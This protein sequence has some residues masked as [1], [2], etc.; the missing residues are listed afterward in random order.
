M[1]G[2]FQAGGHCSGKGEV[3]GDMGRKWM[4]SAAI[5]IAWC[6]VWHLEGTQ[7]M[8]Q[9][10]NEASASQWMDGQRRESRMADHRVTRA[11]WDPLPEGPAGSKHSPGPCRAGAAVSPRHPE[12]QPPEG[13]LSVF[14]LLFTLPRT[15]T[16]LL[17]LLQAAFCILS[18]AS[19]PSLIS[20]ISAIH[21]TR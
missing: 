16:A 18:C 12:G 1:A 9:G 11:L 6:G 5:L 17:S 15:P 14:L 2:G 10:R 3:R 7:S 21:T 19:S 4:V 13:T 20:G 8:R